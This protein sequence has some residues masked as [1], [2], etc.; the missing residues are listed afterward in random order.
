MWILSSS[1]EV[2]TL[3]SSLIYLTMLNAFHQ[4]LKALPYQIPLHSILL[5]CFH[6]WLSCF[7]FRT[8]SM[9]L[10]IT[11]WTATALAFFREI[12]FFKSFLKKIFSHWFRNHGTDK[13]PRDIYP[14]DRFW[15]QIHVS[16][17]FVQCTFTNPE[18]W[19][20][21]RSSQRSFWFCYTQ[22]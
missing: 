9:C 21:A 2:S 5:S 15:T 1:R 16:I 10:Y 14:H 17:N 19:C 12:N 20:I 7:A 4:L 18:L 13:F 22:V 11:K 3:T 6:R 8:S